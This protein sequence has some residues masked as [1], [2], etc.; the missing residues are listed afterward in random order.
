MGPGANVLKLFCPLF[1]NTKLECVLDYARKAFQRQTI[2][3][4]TNNRNL[5][6]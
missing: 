5:Q 6:T 3:L 1:K 2:Q 4:I